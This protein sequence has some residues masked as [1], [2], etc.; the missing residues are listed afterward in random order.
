MS[1]K[2]VAIFLFFLVSIITAREIENEDDEFI[3]GENSDEFV[4]QEYEQD[5]DE[6]IGE[7]LERDPSEPKE[8]DKPV[9][10]A[11]PETQI[12]QPWYRKYVTEIVFAVII[13]AFIAQCYRGQ[14]YN[15]TLVAAWLGQNIDFFKEQFALI[16]IEHPPEGEAPKTP[17][18]EGET[19]MRGAFLEQHSHNVFKFFATGRVNCEYCLVTFEL[20]RRQDLF[21]MATFNILWPEVDK[22]V[23]EIPLLF[24]D[25]FP[26]VFALVRRNEMKTL[27]EENKLLV[28]VLASHRK[29]TPLSD[30]WMTYRGNSAC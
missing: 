12:P 18:F 25:S 20:K 22:V 7:P 28:R 21:T 5:N 24:A 3:S 29:I 30:T 19:I 11:E 13:L 8:E 17:V 27:L 2:Q 16:G 14:K 15:K 26:C 23:Y 10:V 9:V 1:R 4:G 6:F